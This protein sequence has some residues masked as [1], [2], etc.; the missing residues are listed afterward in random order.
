MSCLLMI[1][2][3]ILIYLKIFPTIT[4]DK[5]YNLTYNMLK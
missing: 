2:I 3:D 1:D 4:K 5:L